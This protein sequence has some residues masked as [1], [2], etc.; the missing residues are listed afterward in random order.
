MFLSG[1]VVMLVFIVVLVM[2]LE[3]MLISC[4]LKGLGIRYFVLK[5]SFLL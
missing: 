2:V 1:F 3:M 4:G 5:V